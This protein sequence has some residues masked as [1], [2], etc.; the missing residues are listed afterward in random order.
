M[1]LLHEPVPSPTVT[2]TPEPGGQA[3]PSATPSQVTPS[4]SV[5]PS[6]QGDGLPVTGPDGWLLLV[7]LVLVVLGTLIVATTLG[8]RRRV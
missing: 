2:V 1:L 4:V 7:A 5:S 3:A 6:G 8:R